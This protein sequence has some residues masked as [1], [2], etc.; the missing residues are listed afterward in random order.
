MGCVHCY[1]F[2][3]PFLYVILSSSRTCSLQAWD[4]RSHSGYCIRSIRSSVSITFSRPSLL[5]R[6]FVLFSGSLAW[7]NDCVF[8]SST[9]ELGY[10]SVG[11]NSS[12]FSSFALA[13]F[14]QY[15]LRK[16]AS[17]HPLLFRAA[18]DIFSR[19]RATWFRKYKYSSLVF[20]V[21]SLII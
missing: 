3:I 12:I 4:S 10:L 15:Y 9:A 14:S 19:Y 7:S 20:Y 5:A 17:V 18:H 1:T 8:L 13:I 16:Y 11:I 21:T 2:L 6:H